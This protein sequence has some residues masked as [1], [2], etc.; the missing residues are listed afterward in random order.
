M[1]IVGLLQES[2]QRVKSNPLI[3][4]PV[5]A[6]TVLIALVSLILVGTMVPRIGGIGE[7]GPDTVVT[8]GEAVGYAGMAVG[9]MIALMVI[10][11]I[12]GLL[13][14]GMTVLMADD[15]LNDRPVG[16]SSAWQR[17]RPRIW[18]LVATSV[19]VGILV[20]LGFMLLVLPGV[21]LAFLL[22]FTFVALML[23]ETGPFG[24]MGSSFRTVTAHF[25]T[26][27]VFFLVIIALGLLVGVV[28]FV[29]ALIPVLGAI[30]TILVTSAYLSFLSVFVVAVFRGLSDS[31]GGSP[32]PEA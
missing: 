20:S 24:A 14:H 30:L 6:A 18:A 17:V 9:R 3:L 10:S 27:F 5:L 26:V 25:G 7:I 16:L 11:S 2:F 4:I 21:V 31:T 15:A 22:M 12:V 13:A 23:Q 1:N 8:A 29:V 32:A 28:N 19:V